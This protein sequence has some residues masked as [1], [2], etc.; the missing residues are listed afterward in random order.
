MAIEDA[1]V[2][3]LTLA[4]SGGK[5]SDVALALQVYQTIRRPRVAASTA[6]GRQVCLI[7]PIG[8]LS[9]TPLLGHSNKSTGTGTRRQ[10]PTLSSLPSPATFTTL[11][12]KPTPSVSF[13]THLERSLI[14]ETARTL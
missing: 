9:L 11:T 10:G 14:L 5:S 13:A 4:L 7:S 12:P 1:A 8:P 3:A 2:L 6:A